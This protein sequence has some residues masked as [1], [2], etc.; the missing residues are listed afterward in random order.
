MVPLLLN[1]FCYCG[2]FVTVVCNFVTVSC[3]LLWCISYFG[4]FVAV[5]C[6][7]LWCFCYCGVCYCGVFVIVAGLLL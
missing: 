3:L 6:M 5:V 2:V 4:V 1:G 7:L